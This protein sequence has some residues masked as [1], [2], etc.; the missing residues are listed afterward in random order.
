MQIIII[1]CIKKLAEK[2]IYRL[3]SLLLLCILYNTGVYQ[4]W[5]QLMAHQTQAI[6]RSCHALPD[7]TV[8]QIGCV[9]YNKVMSC[10]FKQ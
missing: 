6:R 7:S 10:P 4:T 5:Y 2:L 3:Y 9:N 1:S 8:M